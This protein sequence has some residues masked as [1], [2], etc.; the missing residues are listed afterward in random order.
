MQSRPACFWRPKASLPFRKGIAAAEGLIAI[1]SARR[2]CSVGFSDRARACS[3]AG[4]LSGARHCWGFSGWPEERARSRSA[5]G[6]STGGQ[7]F[8]RFATY[9]WR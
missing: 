4:V 6:R 7:D 9:T 5:R 1:P 2:A 3:S 8:R